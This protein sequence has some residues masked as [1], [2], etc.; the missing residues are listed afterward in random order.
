MNVN[1]V[2]LSMHHVAVTSLS[3][4]NLGC[5]IQMSCKASTFAIILMMQ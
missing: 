4:Y 5:K 2:C 1:V 3:S